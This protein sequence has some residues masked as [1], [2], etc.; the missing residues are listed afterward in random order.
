MVLEKSQYATP[1]HFMRQ[2][3]ETF[4]TELSLELEKSCDIRIARH[5][6]FKFPAYGHENISFTIF[7]SDCVLL[8]KLFAFAFR[9]DQ[10]WIQIR[11]GKMLAD[12]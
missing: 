1:F 5:H 9:G 6:E 4:P 11:D 12:C 2:R 3:I 10:T 8:L 7:V